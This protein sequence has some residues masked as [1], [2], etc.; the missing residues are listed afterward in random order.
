MSRL[1]NNEVSINSVLAQCLSFNSQLF[2]FKTLIHNLTEDCRASRESFTAAIDLANTNFSKAMSAKMC[3]MSNNTY[4]NVPIRMNFARINNTLANG[5][6][7]TPYSSFGLDLE[8]NKDPPTLY[9][10][11]TPARR[12]FSEGELALGCNDLDGSTVGKKGSFQINQFKKADF[13]DGPDC[14]AERQ[15]IS[16]YIKLQSSGS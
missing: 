9:D 4:V 3:F 10:W 5:D 13:I 15:V 1:I 12:I 14:F 2:L 7:G 11:M 16:E 8:T 6:K